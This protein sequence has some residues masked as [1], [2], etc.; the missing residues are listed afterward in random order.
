MLSTKDTAGIGSVRDW[1]TAERDKAKTRLDALEA[2][3]EGARFDFASAERMLELA[4]GGASSNGRH[5]AV[6]VSDVRDC[7]T[8]RDIARR[9]A[10][11]SGGVVNV[12]KVALLIHATGRWG[13]KESS[14]KSTMNSFFCKHTDEW[15][16]VEPGTFRW[17]RFN[18]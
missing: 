6:T 8:Q 10:E 7:K 3:V 11:L 17:K 15:E 2:E 12:T 18:Q 4:P 16:W 9:V 14:L 5:P 13:A 1:L